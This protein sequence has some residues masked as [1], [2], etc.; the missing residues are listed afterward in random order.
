[1][2]HSSNIWLTAFPKILLT[3]L[4]IALVKFECTFQIKIS[5]FSKFLSFFTTTYFKKTKCD[6]ISQLL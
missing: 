2:P 3:Y 1:M 6:K 4:E 5:D